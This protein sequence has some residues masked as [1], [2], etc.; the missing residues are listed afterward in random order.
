[1]ARVTLEGKAPPLKTCVKQNGWFGLP[2]FLYIP[3]LSF[4]TYRLGTYY[5]QT[6][7]T[8]KG[9]E[10]VDPALA[11]SVRERNTPVVLG[12]LWRC[13]RCSMQVEKRTV[14]RQGQR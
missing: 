11:Q 6:G 14:W 12:R 5:V 7:D 2:S 13:Y 3:F 1:M 4:D 10:A 8:H 9:E